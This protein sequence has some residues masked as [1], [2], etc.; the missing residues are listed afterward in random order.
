MADKNFI[1]QGHTFTDEGVTGNF[2]PVSNFDPLL[3]LHEGSNFHIVPDLTTVKIDE[4]VKPDV[5][6]QFHVRSHPLKQML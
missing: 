4:I 2:A 1:F 3:N 6:T 5:F